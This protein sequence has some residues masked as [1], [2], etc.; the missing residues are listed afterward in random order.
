MKVAVIFG[1][2]GFLG[3][4]FS[5]Y[6]VI[7]KKYNKIYLY[8]LQVKPYSQYNYNEKL[9]NGNDK[10]IR[11]N[12]DVRKN[13]EWE[14][15]EKINLIANFAAVHREPGHDAYEY[16]ETNILG[17]ENICNWA[18]RIECYNMLFTSSIAP[19]GDMPWVKNEST[20][21]VPDTP[22]GC[23]KLIAEKINILWHSK[24]TKEKKLLIIRPGVVFGPGE[25][26]N[27][28]RLI[29]AIKNGYFIYSGNKKTIKAGVYIK[30]LCNAIGSVLCSKDF[31]NKKVILFN[32]TMNPPPT[33]ENYVQSISEILN[34]KPFAPSIPPFILITIAYIIQFLCSLLNHT[35]SINP[36]RVRKLSKSN[37]VI[38]EY[39]IRNKYKYKYT[40]DEALRDWKNINQNDW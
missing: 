23:S 9:I 3:A 33:V 31:E 22:Y 18:D 36:T 6:L 13:I 27:V 11:I 32:M 21:P 38:P 40:L 34:K 12:G 2:F 5:D 7:N 19:Y 4:H 29:K 35:S 30:E 17:S 26:G 8:D 25:G 28:T 15:K 14:P 20:L 37:N 16:Y 1:G 39:L 24:L 10:I